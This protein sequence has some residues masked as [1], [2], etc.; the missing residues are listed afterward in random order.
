[1]CDYLH[2]E[3]SNV[4]SLYSQLEGLMAVV[5]LES[6]NL[7]STALAM[8]VV[9]GGDDASLETTLLNFGERLADAGVIP[10]MIGSFPV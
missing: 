5:A 4:L 9:K 8:T 1:M 2:Q 10:H 6:G 3:K 7:D